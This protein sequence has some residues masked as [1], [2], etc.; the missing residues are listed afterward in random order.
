MHGT[1]VII[2]DHE[3]IRAI[4][5]EVLEEE[6]YAVAIAANGEDG[7]ATL[8]RAPRPCVALL[9]LLMPVMSGWE[10]LDRIKAD[11][12]L[13]AVPVIILTGALSS[14]QRVDIP[15]AAAIFRK[16]VDP[17]DLLATLEKVMP[18]LH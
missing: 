14:R 8:R 3:D 1:V 11:P 6:G 4:L 18:L 10:L 15:G 2:D 16:P 13:A 17:Y 12:E 9:D 5:Q 7:L